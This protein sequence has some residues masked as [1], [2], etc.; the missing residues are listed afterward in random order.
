MSF[1]AY[2]DGLTKEASVQ[3]KLDEHL[4]GL[5][6]QASDEAETE[7][8]LAKASAEELAKIAGIS[9]P[10]D[11]CPKC[12]RTMQKLGSVLQCEC[13]RIK[14]AQ[15]G[16]LNP[17]VRSAGRAGLRTGTRGA[18]MLGRVAQTPA[19]ARAPLL[20]GSTAGALTGSELAALGPVRGTMARAGQKLKGLKG[21]LFGGGRAP[22]PALAKVGSVGVRRIV[23]SGLL[24][25]GTGALA[26]GEDNRA[27]GALIGAGLGAG[28]GAGAH[29][30]LRNPSLRVQG[31]KDPAAFVAKLK[32]GA[33]PGVADL[34]SGTPEQKLR[35]A[36]LGWA[37]QTGGMLAGGAGAGAL[38][39]LATRAATQP[40]EVKKASLT[41][42]AATYCATNK[43]PE[44]TF[45]KLA[46]EGYDGLNFD[47]DALCGREGEVGA[48]AQKLAEAAEPKTHDLCKV[49][50]E[51]LLQVGHEAGKLMTKLSAIGEAR[52]TPDELREAITEAKAREDI[53]GR[54]RKWG[55]KG[56][57][58]GGLGG[59]LAGAGLG[60]GAS[61]LMGG[62]GRVLA[63]ALGA[64]GGAAGGGFLGHRLGRAEGAEEAAADKLV[65]AIRAQR[66]YQAGGMRGFM[67]GRAM[68]NP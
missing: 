34:A 60:Y 54:A 11:A 2:L 53:P 38:G 15:I 67:A 64:L 16:V 10:E 41:K 25:A 17:L 27:L 20:T 23:G 57:L 40:D 13:G 59:G 22:A 4:A 66:A 29:L 55:I 1:E 45:V 28:A 62:K 12:A 14:K 42:V 63:P 18:K 33:R 52:L 51:Q 47:L 46:S 48:M 68:G 8:F 3:S 39:G 7:A 31:V 35:R 58:G 19:Q 9:L 49:G 5:V 36:R 24:G 6:K 56:A 21:S 43:D 32:G 37:L 44:D 61:A 30:L 26:A 50:A 65:S